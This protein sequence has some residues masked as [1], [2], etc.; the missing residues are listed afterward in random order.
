MRETW[1]SLEMSR[2]DGFWLQSRKAILPGKAIND[3]LACL[4]RRDIDKITTVSTE[5]I[6]AKALE[7]SR[8]A[9]ILLVEEIW[10]SIAAEPDDLQLSDELR[11][12]LDSR[13]ADY[14]KNPDE[15][16]SWQEVRERLLRKP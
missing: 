15:G 12:E 16:S 9:R 6:L 2:R 4:T 14:H 11:A 13:L 7:L 8:A 1:K 10:D 5:T 3:H